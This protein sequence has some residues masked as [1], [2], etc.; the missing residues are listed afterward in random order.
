[1]PS[2]VSAEEVEL[3]KSGD[4]INAR[5][6]RVLWAARPD[7]NAAPRELIAENQARESVGY[8]SLYPS[9]IAPPALLAELP[10]V[11]YHQLK[12]V[13]ATRIEPCTLWMQPMQ[14][15]VGSS[16]ERRTYLAKIAAS[17]LQA[18]L[19]AMHK[20]H[21]GAKGSDLYISLE[22]NGQNQQASLAE[23]QILRAIQLVE[24]PY[25]G[26]LI[27]SDLVS[28]KTTAA[29]AALWQQEPL[30]AH[31]DSLRAA[32][33]GEYFASHPKLRYWH[34]SPQEAIP[35]LHSEGGYSKQYS[36]PGGHGFF[37]FQALLV[38]AQPSLRPV[39]TFPLLAMIYNGE[40]L[41]PKPFAEISQWI[42][43]KQLP[44]A[45][46][47]TTKTAVDS[48][49]GQIALRPRAQQGGRAGTSLT[50]VELSQAERAGQ[51][52]LF[53]QLG[54]RPGDHPAYFNTNIVV[55]NYQ[56]LSPLLE[57]LYNE[58][59][60]EQFSNIIAP[61]VMVSKKE[62]VEGENGQTQSCFQLEGALASVMLNLDRYW[63]ERF[64]T[65]LVGFVNVGVEERFEFFAPIKNS[66][67][68]FRLFYSDC[69]YFDG[70]A[71]RFLA[72]APVFLPLCSFANSAYR[73]LDFVLTVFRGCQ[74]ARLKKLQVEGLVD[75]S[76]SCLEGSI[77]IINQT[78]SLVRVADLTALSRFRHGE[79][80]LLKDVGIVLPANGEEPAVVSVPL[81]YSSHSIT[82]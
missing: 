8:P 34:L 72:L 11:H 43:E 22:R 77:H 2:L 55:L 26:E 80:L 39:S 17:R 58:L 64:G 16:L 28:D 56:V 31:N 60:E 18:G 78:P 67:D 7:L 10:L 42:L 65:G 14:A 47:T 61:T 41:S 70:Q 20:H 59:G 57:K 50:I 24:E 52:D 54:L 76:G 69:F 21:T 5:Y 9:A 74:I 68:F 63:R 13:P 1:M 46:I 81:R 35:A 33:Y 15:G 66:F 49:G 71:L 23:V 51:R 40:D 82:L 32:S 62:L 25:I 3:L 45:M 36:A 4:T 48:K 79:R 12:A 73:D 27:Y 30:L 53:L 29:I 38:A 44:I 19:P 75:F 6:A 37:G